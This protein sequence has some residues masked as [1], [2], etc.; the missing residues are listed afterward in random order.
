M[1]HKR[2]RF[3]LL[4]AVCA[5]AIILSN[6]GNPTNNN[7]SE[8]PTTPAA[9]Q[10]GVLVYGSGGQPV[11]LEP[12]N[13]TDGNSIIVQQQIYNRLIEF[14][15]GTTEFQPSLATSWSVSADGKVWTF[16][17]RPGV[18]F[19]DGSDF[20]AEAVKFNVE[21][22]WNPQH[23][24]GYR[25]AGKSYEIW[26]QLFGG[27]K[28]KSESLLQDVVVVDNSTIQF[29]LKQPFAAFPAAIGSGYFGIASPAA[30]KKAAASYGTPGSLAVGTG[31]FIFKEWRTGDRILLEKNPNYWKKGDP[32]I[33]QLVIRFITDPAAR[34]AQLRAGQIDFT[35][36]LAPDQ[37]KEVESDANL[38]AIPR[39]SFNVGY[40]A[41][42]PSYKPLGDAKVRQAIALAINN[43]QIV[44]AFWGNLGKHDSHFT[45]PSLNWAQ[46]SKITEYNYN[47]QKAKQLLAQAG[48]P[49]GFDLELWYMPVS[50]PYFPT[51][52]PIAE[53]FAAD[54]SAIGIRV[55]L[56]TKDW[57]AYLSDR[58]KPPGFQAFMLGWTPDYGD[59]DSFYYPHFSPA[60]TDDIG[61]WKNDKVT[62]LLNLGRAT[63]DKAARAKIYAEVD[64]ILHN[65]A[66]RLPIVHSQPLLAKR[67]NIEGW[68]PSPLG[69]ESFEQIEKK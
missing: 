18:K 13:I 11:N 64:E 65:E 8:N 5:F 41:L 63:G 68:I 26:Q 61:N 6:C 56:N 9:T 20:N 49:T 30:I 22:W 23:P 37:R 33:N 62:Q 17:L 54:L 46:S 25:N 67:K 29:K 69:S 12:G 60:A 36:D 53:A 55:K 45:P 44:Q 21:R 2:W 35:V 57:A 34:L 24:N 51:P 28:G 14:K 39:P 3:P 31:P 48:Y 4:A 32:K 58:R 47:P 15:P 40:L 10:Q 27:F 52:K 1:N 66:V 43:D 7:Q 16:K 19:H 59:P 42:N 38:V 50:R